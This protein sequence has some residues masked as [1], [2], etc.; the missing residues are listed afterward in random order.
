MSEHG[1]PI[2]HVIEFTHRDHQATLDRALR[3]YQNGQE[4]TYKML[5]LA[6]G[7]A[8]FVVPLLAG[9]RG[10]TNLIMMRHAME[11]VATAAVIGVSELVIGRWLFVYQLKL[12]FTEFRR[13]IRVLAAAGD[14]RVQLAKASAELETGGL[15]MQRKLARLLMLAGLGDLLFYTPLLA[16]IVEIGRAVMAG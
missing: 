4:H 13:Q 1:S 2:P 5:T 10:F 7:L 15:P 12:L 3:A 11:L 14:D 9:Q 8:G 6:V 16:G